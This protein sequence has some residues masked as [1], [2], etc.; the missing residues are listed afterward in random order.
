MN[1]IFVP[2]YP[3]PDGPNITQLCIDFSA[4]DPHDGVQFA[5]VMKNPAGL[6]IDKTYTNLAGEDWQDWPPEQTA[7]ADYNYVKNVVLNN[8]GYT[9]AIAPFFIEQPQNVNVNNGQPVSFTCLASGDLPISYQ[10]KKAGSIISGAISNV[11]NIESA[12]ESDVGSYYV[13]VSNAA[14]N[15]ESIS[16]SLNI[17]APPTISIQPI[18]VTQESGT[19]CQFNVVAQGAVPLTYQWE[20]DGVAIPEANNYVYELSGIS[21]LDAGNYIVTVTNIAGSIQSD[22][23]TLTVTNPPPPPPVPTGD[24]P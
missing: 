21:D 8:L 20:K 18:S 15:C 5:V 2:V 6:V 24:N 10:W 12:T 3:K 1:T 19:N 17:N 7:G 22:T 14:G 9:E 11:Y 13:N 4:F 16:A 23:A